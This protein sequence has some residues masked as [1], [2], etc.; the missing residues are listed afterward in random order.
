MDN[1]RRLSRYSAELKTIVQVLSGED[2]GKTFEMITSNV[3][4]SGAFIKT[5]CPLPVGSEL[6]VK[7][8]LPLSKLSH[9]GGKDSLIQFNGSVTHT[10]KDGMGVCFDE[11]VEIGGL[12]EESE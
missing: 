6:K 4:S 1:M 8:I 3:S 5:E 9:L 7:I 10:D 11:D 12:P 2:E